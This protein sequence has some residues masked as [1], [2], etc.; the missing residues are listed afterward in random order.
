MTHSVHAP[1]ESPL[2]RTERLF[3]IAEVLRARRT[4]VTAQQLADRF[5][6]SVR[7]IYRDLD[8]MRVA[9]LP[10]NA[11]PGPG[12]GYALDRSYTLPPIHLSAREAALLVS[13][14]RSVQR[15]RLFPF[16]RTLD[17]A[18][19]K[20]LSALTPAVRARADRLAE[21]L[22]VVG[23]PSLP[24]EDAVR[25]AVERAWIEDRAILF[26]Y[27]GA[28]GTTRRRAR[29]RS[30]VVDGHVTLINATDLDLNVPRQFRLDRMREV[31]LEKR[32]T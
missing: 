10:V 30:V 21:S 1:K 8:A 17:D 24:V 13:V 6:V 11:D 16:A 20:I 23:V 7:T 32:G 31:A 28:R 4:G 12:G 5:G 22:S 27:D 26:I 3:A 18:L 29:V 19:E 15:A 2:K 14:L 9:H 25:D